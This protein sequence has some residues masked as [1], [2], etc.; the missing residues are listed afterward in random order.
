MDIQEQNIKRENTRHSEPFSLW[1]SEKAAPLSWRCSDVLLPFYRQQCAGRTGH[2]A[3]FAIRPRY[4]AMC[5]IGGSAGE[6]SGMTIALKHL[7]A[8]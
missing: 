3:A 8:R 7:R 4:L 5:R 1:C 2:L 6:A